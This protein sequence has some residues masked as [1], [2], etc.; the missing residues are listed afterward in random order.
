MS[1]RIDEIEADRTKLARYCENNFRQKTNYPQPFLE[2]SYE[3][4]EK[5]LRRQ[6]K[7]VEDVFLELFLEEMLDPL[8]D[9]E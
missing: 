3:D 8:D 2:A 9:T 7:L 1:K 6:G 5:F 4:L